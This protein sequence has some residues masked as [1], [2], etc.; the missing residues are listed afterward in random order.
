MLGRYDGGGGRARGWETACSDD[1]HGH[2]RSQILKPEQ[3]IGY[4]TFLD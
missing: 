1:V 2:H 3:L 4:E